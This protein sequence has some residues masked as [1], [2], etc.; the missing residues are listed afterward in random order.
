M[1]RQRP[2]V[3][4]APS[5]RWT[6]GTDRILPTLTKMH[7]EGAIDLRLAEDLAW[8]EM[9]DLVQDCDIVLDQFTTGAYGTF[10]CEAMA[11]G[12]PVVA[13]I[14]E[15]VSRAVG[16]DLPILNATPVTLGKVIEELID[17]RDRAR[18]IGVRSLAFAR[19]YHDGTWT[20]RVLGDFL[21]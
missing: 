21:T 11:A 2:I 7:D 3:L 19:S 8:S 12:K 17:D 18:R 4:H 20:A 6:K 14:S 16:A 10:A 13:Y 5:T 9:R 15:R 1:E